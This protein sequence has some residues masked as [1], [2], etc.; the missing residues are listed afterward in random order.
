MKL[1]TEQFHQREVDTQKVDSIMYDGY[2]PKAT[3]K[4]VNGQ[5]QV[6]LSNGWNKPKYV[7]EIK[8]RMEQFING[9]P[10]PILRKVVALSLDFLKATQTEYFSRSEHLVLQLETNKWGR[11]ATVDERAEAIRSMCMEWYMVGMFR[12]PESMLM[13]VGK[14]LDIAAENFNKLDDD[15]S[16]A[17][18]SVYI[19]CH[20]LY[21]YDRILGIHK[22]GKCSMDDFMFEAMILIQRRDPNMLEEM[23]NLGV[24]LTIDPPED[25]YAADVA[26]AVQTINSH[27]R[28]FNVGL[29]LETRPASLDLRKAISRL[30]KL[31]QNERLKRLFGMGSTTWKAITHDWT[32][33]AVT[34]RNKMADPRWTY[35]IASMLDDRDVKPDKVD[36]VLDVLFPLKNDT[37]SDVLRNDLLYRQLGFDLKN[38]IESVMVVASSGDSDIGLLKAM[39]WLSYL[40]LNLPEDK[41]YANG[42]DVSYTCLMSMLDKY[43][44]GIPFSFIIESMKALVD[45]HTDNHHAAVRLRLP[46]NSIVTIGLYDYPHS[47]TV[48]ERKGR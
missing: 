14:V 27:Y 22:D 45:K 10:D 48:N 6:Q 47:R 43:N 15:S 24:E 11:C 20:L 5:Y 41:E 29:D 8:L 33:E 46:T 13:M 28:R 9:E 23:R 34:A 31:M 25:L 26:L 16:R 36:T 1:I 30:S 2:G 12:M 40:F 18:Y 19:N 7:D 35:A 17:G 21:L 4:L 3:V 44:S 39:A 42:F 37:E 38:M 32:D